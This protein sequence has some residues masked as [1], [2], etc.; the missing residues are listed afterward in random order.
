MRTINDPGR[1]LAVMKVNIRNEIYVILTFE[2]SAYFEQASPEVE[3]NA[4]IFAELTMK[5]DDKS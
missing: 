1:F 3:P 2:S 4:R 5:L